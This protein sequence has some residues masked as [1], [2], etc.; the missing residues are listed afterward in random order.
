MKQKKNNKQYAVRDYPFVLSYDHEDKVYVARAVDLSGCHS[1]GD[2]PEQAT[3]NIYEAITGWLET[4]RK[5]KLPIPVP[6]QMQ[7]R[8][9]KFLLRIEAVNAAK[10]ETLAAASQKSIN[11]LINEAISEL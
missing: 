1:D 8:P 6:S 10:L 9:K 7:S 3:H 11:A 5:N 2:T 4:A